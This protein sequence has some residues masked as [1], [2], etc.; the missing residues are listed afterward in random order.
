MVLVSFVVDSCAVNLFIYINAHKNLIVVCL[1]WFK[2]S[3]NMTTICCH[4]IEQIRTCLKYEI[5]S[6]W[7][8]DWFFYSY[9]CISRLELWSI[10][11]G[12]PGA[13]LVKKNIFNMH[14]IKKFKKGTYVEIPNDFQNMFKFFIAFMVYE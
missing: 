14:A 3:E 9:W 8:C 4:K 6:S 7:K 13:W 11:A 2:L 1:L 12:R 5:L 10:L